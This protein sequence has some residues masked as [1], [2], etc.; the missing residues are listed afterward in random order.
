LVLWH[1]HHSEGRYRLAGGLRPFRAWFCGI[2][3]I[4]RGV[5]ASLEDYALFRVWFC[6]I[7]IIARG[8]TASLEDYALSGLYLCLGLAILCNKAF[9]YKV[10]RTQILVVV[11][12]R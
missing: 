4:A 12:S 10:Q 9:A 2:G 5:T 6:G 3:I 1:R 8:V 11:D 7:G